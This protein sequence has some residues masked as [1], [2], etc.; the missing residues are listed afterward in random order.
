MDT[1]LEEV[2]RLFSAWQRFTLNP[3]SDS[4][5][6]FWKDFLF[7]HFLCHGVI[8]KFEK[9]WSWW[10]D[11]KPEQI[12]CLQILYKVSFGALIGFPQMVKLKGWLLNTLLGILFQK[13]QNWGVIMYFFLLSV[14]F[15]HFIIPFDAIVE[16]FVYCWQAYLWCLSWYPCCP[17]CQ[18][19]KGLI[20]PALWATELEGESVPK[21]KS[22]TLPRS[23]R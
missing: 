7:K 22:H 23:P 14:L 21:W 16:L 6:Q 10:K 9:P 18:K 3:R 4:V 15:F 8:P 5:I 11:I 20:K 13:Y 1:I 19:V 2:L 12:I 17:C